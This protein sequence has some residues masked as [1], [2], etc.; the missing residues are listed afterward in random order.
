MSDNDV[1]ARGT[2]GAEENGFDKEAEREKLR[3][4]FARDEEKRESTRRMSEL[5][6]QGATMTNRHCD[7]CGDPLFRQNG[8]EFCATCQAEGPDGDGVTEQDDVEPTEQRAETT[9]DRSTDAADRSGDPAGQT[10][11]DTSERRRHTT[12]QRRTPPSRVASNNGSR[13]PSTRAG[14]RSRSDG[15][16]TE[17][18]PSPAAAPAAESQASVGEASAEIDEARD[19]LLAALTRHA[20]ASAST[21]NPRT[22]CDHLAAAR[23][24]AEALSALRR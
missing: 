24:A 12:D 17:S 2:D 4:K 22:A 20:T 23:E 8:Q 1:D 19:A 14:T 5:L 18:A 7:T 3:E 21:D 6:L 9:A 13:S 16:S 15:R 11:G 10:A